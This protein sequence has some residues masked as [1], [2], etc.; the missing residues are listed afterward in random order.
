MTLHAHWAE[1]VYVSLLHTEVIVSS[2]LA[3]FGWIWWHH[4]TWSYILI[5]K[6]FVLSEVRRAAAVRTP[7]KHSS[8]TDH[9]MDCFRS[10][11]SACSSLDEHCDSHLFHE[12]SAPGTNSL[13]S[14]A[15]FWWCNDINIQTWCTH[16]EKLFKQVEHTNKFSLK[17]EATLHVQVYILGGWHT[18]M[19]V[20]AQCWLKLCVIYTPA[21]IRD[22]RCV[23]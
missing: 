7:L 10:V 22:F 18:E 2:V 13:A 6:Q 15:L 5:L 1:D 14:T 8:I 20:W 11:N 17:Q 16:L 23:L 4:V 3:E 21:V 19:W 9:S 12:L